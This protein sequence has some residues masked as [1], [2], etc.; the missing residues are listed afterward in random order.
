MGGVEELRGEWCIGFVK[1]TLQE[2]NTTN[3]ELQVFPI[4]QYFSHLYFNICDIL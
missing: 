2:F 1:I 4:F 3:K